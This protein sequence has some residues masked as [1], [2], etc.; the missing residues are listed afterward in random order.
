MEYQTVISSLIPR[1]V[2]QDETVPRARYE[3]SPFTGKTRIKRK[4]R[5]P[6]SQDVSD[7]FVVVG[8]LEHHVLVELM[9][10]RNIVVPRV[11]GPEVRIDRDREV[12]HRAELALVAEV[13]KLIV[14]KPTR[15]LANS[16][17]CGI[18]KLLWRETGQRLHISDVHNCPRRD[19]SVARGYY[20]VKM[21]YAV[22]R[23][24]CLHRPVESALRARGR[25]LGVGQR[26][27]N[28]G[29]VR[30]TRDK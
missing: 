11:W 14:S 3:I 4:V 7:I 30:A 17:A 1:S 28:T 25:A 10:N 29:S 6:Y 15:S 16:D 5:I 20:V 27:R 22:Q 19:G 21:I 24:A 9:L 18:G 26:L 2:P 13:P 23:M 12:T 8:N